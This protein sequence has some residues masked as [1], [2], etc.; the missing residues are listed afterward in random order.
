MRPTSIAAVTEPPGEW[1]KI[2][3]LCFPCRASSA[4]SRAG[5]PGSKV[6]SAAIH[7]EQPEP[8]AFGSP[9][10]MKKTIGGGGGSFCGA[11]AG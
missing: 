3:S 5:A 4:R 8:Q 7:S 11:G 6:P 2:G 1:R 10:A 9:L